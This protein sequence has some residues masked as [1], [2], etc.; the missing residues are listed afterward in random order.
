MYN[1]TQTSIAVLRIKVP[2]LQ[3]P[4]R[5]R[6]IRIEGDIHLL[7]R[8]TKPV[9][10]DLLEA[11]LLR[12]VVD[13][14]GVRPVVEVEID[15]K[16][17]RILVPHLE[18]MIVGLEDQIRLYEGV[19]EAGMCEEDEEADDEQED[20]G[21]EGEVQT[22]DGALHGSSKSRDLQGNGNVLQ[23]EAKLNWFV[24]D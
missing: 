13:L 14:V 23:T 17:D 22:E 5:H 7:L 19:N 3:M 16:G 6:I 11:G 15:G 1:I 12:V 21:G 10:S 20:G 4:E 2:I 9:R 18:Q 24:V 8:L